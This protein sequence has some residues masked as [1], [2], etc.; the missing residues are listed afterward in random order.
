MKT[1]PPEFEEKTTDTFSLAHSFFAGAEGGA[2][3]GGGR[4]ALVRA[5]TSVGVDSSRFFWPLD[6]PSGEGGG[7]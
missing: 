1:C 7:K 2:G 3:R 5:E 4:A 6:L